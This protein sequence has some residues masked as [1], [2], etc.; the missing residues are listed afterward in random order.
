LY[1]FCTK[2]TGFLTINNLDFVN[3][4]HTERNLEYFMI[5]DKTGGDRVQIQILR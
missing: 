3:A 5:L 1:F 4:W 2:V